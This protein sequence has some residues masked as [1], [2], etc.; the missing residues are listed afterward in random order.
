MAVTAAPDGGYELASLAVTTAAGQAVA[1]TP[2]G[3]G[4]STFTM[5]AGN[6]TVTAMFAAI[7]PDYAACDGGAQCPLRAFADLNATAWYH[8]GIH[9]CLENGLMNGTGANTF[10]PN[11][12]T[13]RAMIA[14]ILWRLSGSPVV[15]YAMTF[16]DVEPG[17]WYAE[18]VRWAAS[19]RH[20][21]RPGFAY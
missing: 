5:P 8:D 9:Y 12:A 3:N 10:S 18:A 21:F 20:R 1:L 19:R 13:S 15:N 11:G 6:V 7:Q 4:K 14:T 17:S 2:L 16:T